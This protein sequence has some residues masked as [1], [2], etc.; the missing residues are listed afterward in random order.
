MYERTRRV[1]SPAVVQV[2]VSQRATRDDSD[3]GLMGERA[4]ISEETSIGAAS[5]KSPNVA[6]RNRNGMMR[7]E[8]MAEGWTDED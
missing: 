5:A 7:L 3:T 2:Q 1:G 8:N 4:L 6:I